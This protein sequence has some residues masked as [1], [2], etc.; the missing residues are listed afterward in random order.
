MRN[1]TRTKTRAR[2]TEIVRLATAMERARRPTTHSER[3]FIMLII[4]CIQR[5]EVDWSQR[6]SQ[7]AKRRLAGAGANAVRG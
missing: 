5:Q 3:I 2:S 1:S 7:S 4:Y 6:A